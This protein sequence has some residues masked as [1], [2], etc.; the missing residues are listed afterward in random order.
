MNPRRRAIGIVTLVGLLAFP[1]AALAGPLVLTISDGRVILSA[2]DVP[3]RQILAEWEKIGGTRIVNRER[4]PGTLVTLDLANVSEAKALE[5]LLRSVAGY[6][7][8]SRDSA[9][10]GASAYSRIII[11]PGAA[12]LAAA[13]GGP[14]SSPAMS[15]QMGGPQRP[16]MQRRVLADGR[17][18]NY[19]ENPNR[20]GE[21][22]IVDDSD[23]P[24]GDAGLPPSM[25]PP[26]G[27][28][29]RPGM[30]GTMPGDPNQNDSGQDQGA[31]MSPTATPQVGARTLPTPGVLPAVK[32]G[33]PG[34]PPG[35]PK[36]PGY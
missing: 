26:F 14:A 33:Q 15:Q 5:T 27:A 18:I 11:M 28:P 36:P 34:Q 12:N 19:I 13:G 24:G 3:L 35:P 31:A 2:Q 30:P 32:P 25:R 4:V 20:P 23:D 29:G 22:T 16:P 8:V 1:A 17:V 9:S 10:A 6:V 7:A 21:A